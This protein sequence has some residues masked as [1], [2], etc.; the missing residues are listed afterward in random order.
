MF[1]NI[2]NQM[3]KQGVLN[4]PIQFRYEETSFSPGKSEERS[5]IKTL[6]ESFNFEVRNGNKVVDVFLNKVPTQIKNEGL[7]LL[8]SY[9]LM[10]IG[11]DGKMSSQISRVN[12]KVAEFLNN[13]PEIKELNFLE[14]AGS[15]IYF[16]NEFVNNFC[17]DYFKTFPLMSIYTL[18][19]KEKLGRVI[20]VRTE[21]YCNNKKFRCEVRTSGKN[22]SKLFAVKYVE[23]TLC[24][25][26]EGEYY[27]VGEECLSLDNLAR[28]KNGEISGKVGF[29]SILPKYFFVERKRLERIDNG[30]K[31]SLKDIRQKTPTIG[32]YI[33]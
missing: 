11:D 23:E 27:I 9:N 15:N 31:F 32:F 17:L 19:K 16:E 30:Y 8:C 33:I 14:K 6:E 20:L 2:V 28:N 21:E 7:A 25:F 10:K 4:I 12:K 13:F 29:I 22:S 24:S 3:E 5:I 26:K 1:E 18:S